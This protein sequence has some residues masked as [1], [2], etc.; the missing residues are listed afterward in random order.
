MFVKRFDFLPAD[1]MDVYSKELV[2]RFKNSQTDE[3]FLDDFIKRCCSKRKNTKAIAGLA[4][5]PKTGITFESK[6]KYLAM[7]QAMS[8]VLYASTGNE[9]VYSLEVENLADNIELFNLAKKFP[10]DE[11]KYEP[12]GN[13]KEITLVAHKK[14]NLLKLKNYTMN[15]WKKYK[16]G[17]QKLTEIIKSLIMRIFCIFLTPKKTTPKGI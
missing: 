17:F 10:T 5:M 1:F 16:T 8:D 4:I 6:L 9:D 13:G 14:I 3:A 11:R 2:V 12:N 15:I 7:E